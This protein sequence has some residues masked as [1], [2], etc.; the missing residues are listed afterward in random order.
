[1]ISDATP[2]RNPGDTADVPLPMDPGGK[3]LFWQNDL[4]QDV[5][6]SGVPEDL[7]AAAGDEGRL[8][9]AASRTA[10]DSQTTEVVNKR[11]LQI[12]QRIRDKLT[13]KLEFWL[14]VLRVRGDLEPG[15]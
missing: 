8:V 13:G 2:K 1:M 6:F 4:W 7:V 11:A 12:V 14:W 3:T 10:E 5:G 9:G 15:H